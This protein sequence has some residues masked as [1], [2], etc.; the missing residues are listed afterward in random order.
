MIQIIIEPKF[1]LKPRRSRDSGA[2]SALRSACDLGLSQIP[3][4][5]A[6]LDAKRSSPLS[7]GRQVVAVQSLGDGAASFALG[8]GQHASYRNGKL[9]IPRFRRHC[10]ANA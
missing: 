6:F 8:G 10:V 4:Q 3:N 9:A 2:L 5:A 7:P 1:C